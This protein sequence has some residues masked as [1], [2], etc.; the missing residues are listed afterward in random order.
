VRPNNAGRSALPISDGSDR[1]LPLGREH[2]RDRLPRL[3][4]D[5]GFVSDV[6]FEAVKLAALDIHVPRV[7][8]K[9]SLAMIR[10]LMK[11]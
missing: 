11:R 2:R 5:L 9:P 7:G 8:R 6:P 1:D 3:V 10:F 4:F